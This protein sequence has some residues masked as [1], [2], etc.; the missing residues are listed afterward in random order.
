MKDKG[1]DL[2]VCGHV[3]YAHGEKGWGCHYKE[4]CDCKRFQDANNPRAIKKLED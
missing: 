3:R 4:P 1:Y 2:C